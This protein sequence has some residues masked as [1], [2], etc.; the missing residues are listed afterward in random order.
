M[1][2]TTRSKCL[3]FLLYI[4]RFVRSP[5]ILRSNFLGINLGEQNIPLVIG[6]VLLYALHRLDDAE[7][8][9]SI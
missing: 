2:T 5:E 8:Y 4:L 9:A 3:L 1:S 7:K 6:V